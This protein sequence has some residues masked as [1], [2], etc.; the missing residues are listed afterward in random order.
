[1][2][3]LIGPL[4]PAVT[5]LNAIGIGAQARMAVGQLVQSVCQAPGG[6]VWALDQANAEVSAPL[7]WYLSP[8]SR[9]FMEAQLHGVR[10][11]GEAL[12]EA[13]PVSAGAAGCARLPQSSG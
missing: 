2:R 12:D 10:R 13:H 6:A 1:M 11:V 7:G 9:R 5:A 3:F 4:G 8:N